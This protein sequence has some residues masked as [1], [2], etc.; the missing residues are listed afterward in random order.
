[1]IVEYIDNN[2]LS[3]EEKNY[4]KIVYLGFNYNT[5]VNILKAT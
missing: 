5:L 1:M 2:V 4:D 3:F